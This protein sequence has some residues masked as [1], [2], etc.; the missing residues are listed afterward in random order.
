MISYINT[1]YWCYTGWV[2]RVIL[3]FLSYHLTF[4]RITSHL[5]R[6]TSSF[7]YHFHTFYL[8]LLL[9]ISLFL[10]YYFTLWRHEKISNA[11]ERLD[12]C[13]LLVKTRTVMSNKRCDAPALRATVVVLPVSTMPEPA[14]NKWYKRTSFFCLLLATARTA[15]YF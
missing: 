13:L 10:P 8:T 2:K 14:P 11:G 6:I 1:S 7:W 9:L 5:S 4:F 12:F 3:T 15:S